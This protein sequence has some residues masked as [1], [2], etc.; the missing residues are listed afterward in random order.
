MDRI[1]RIIAKLNLKPHPEGGYFRETYRDSLKIDK[2]N[3]GPEYSGNRNCSTCIYFLLTSN[4]FSAFHKI[5]QDEIWHFYQGSPIRLHL[6]SPQGE[7]SNILIGSDLDQG[8]IPQFV[9][10][11]EYWFSGST[12]NDND[13][14]LVGCTVSPGFDFDDFELGQRI[15]LISS[16]PQHREIIEKF[17]R[18]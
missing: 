6:I 10:P 2:A 14:S 12:I 8:Q 18:N 16:F 7:Y 11:K 4:A 9:V 5:R 13:Y 1:E 17:T 15:E 3:L